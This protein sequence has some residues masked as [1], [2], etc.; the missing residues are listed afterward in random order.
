M[1]SRDSR[2]LPRDTAVGGRLASCRNKRMQQH[3]ISIEPGCLWQTSLKVVILICVRCRTSRAYYK[4][5]MFATGPDLLK[6]APDPDL[7]ISRQVCTNCAYLF[8][9]NLSQSSRRSCF[10]AEVHWWIL[11]HACKLRHVAAT[12]QGH[13]HVTPS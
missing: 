9:S 5:S 13:C 3:A 11:T 12:W 6:S 8:F 10:R 4:L 7:L 1:F 2:D